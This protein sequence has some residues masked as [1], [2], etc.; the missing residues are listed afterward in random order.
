MIER[1]FDKELTEL[2]TNL[3]KMAT[4]AE[5][6]IFRSTNALKNRD[7]DMAN[8][9]IKNDTKIDELENIIEESAIELLALKQPLAIDLRFIT[10]GMK[11][12]AELERIADLAVNISQRV[13][14]IVDKPLLKPLI[15]IPKLSE[16]AQKMVKSSIDAFVERDEKKA[17]KIILSDPEANKL[18]KAIQEELIND[19]MAKDGTTATRAVPLLLVVRHL[20]R[21]CDHATNIAEDVIYMVQARVVKHRKLEENGNPDEI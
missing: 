6:A 2:N 16:I 11:I 3:L 7:E 19:Y 21:I 8:N 20:E 13:L 9:V 14:E 18:K 10:T 17:K 15:D 12:N 5:E 1:H 4:L